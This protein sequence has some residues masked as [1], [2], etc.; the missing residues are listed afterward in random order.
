MTGPWTVLR[1]LVGVCLGALLSAASQAAEPVLI[2]HMLWDANQRPLYQQ[3]AKDFERQHPGVRV[4]V[5]QQGWDDYW[6]TL[7]TGFISETAPDVFANHLAKFPE[8]VENQLLLDL[9]PW[10]ARDKFSLDDVV[11]GLAANWARGGRQ[12]ALPAD[13]DTV[14]L[15]VN[16]EMATKA[17]LSL[18]ALRQLRWNPQDGGSF[19]RA[20]ALLTQDQA[21]RHALD[22][23]FD[24]RQ[25]KVWGYQT[26]GA[27]GMMGQTEWS[28]FAVSNGFRY[29]SSPWAID[30][31]Y[32]DP[33]LAQT[34][35]WLGSLARRG[36][37]ATPQ[38]LGT[39]GAESLFSLGRVAMIPTG[40]WMSGHIAR[41]APFKHAWL[42]LPIGP[43][44]QRHSMLNGL[45]HSIWRG[46]RH[47]EQAWAWVRHLGSRNCQLS[48]AQ[49]GVVYP[50]LKGMAE[51]AVSAQAQ[52]GIDAQVFLDMA[53]SATFAPPIVAHAAEISELMDSAISRSVFGGQPAQPLLQR[54]NAQA[55]ALQSP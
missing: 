4:R 12:Y 37:S 33:R 36:I 10:L 29:Q 39:L 7:S 1:K 52:R 21:G 41:T 51:V 27:G 43:S 18:E 20:V 26:P 49:A 19:G 53:R 54:A 50:A 31:R 5:M 42:P 45:G 15:V 55:R 40:S 14:A 32:D 17:G 44:G 48:I 25:V 3:C 11:P 35:D 46:T 23:G 28:H 34:L 24:K 13:W 30:L 16:L 8:Q 47:P 22:P 2:K 6:T 38:Q 9:S